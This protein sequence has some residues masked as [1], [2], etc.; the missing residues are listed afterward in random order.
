MGRRRSIRRTR[1]TSTTCLEGLWVKQYHNVVDVAL[2]KR[3][4]A[5]P[6]PRARAQAVRVLC[7]WRDRVPQGAGAAEN[8][9]QRRRSA[10][11]SRSG[12]RG[13]FLRAA[14]EAKE[15]IHIAQR[16]R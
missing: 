1:S 9:G 16:R 8:R 5:S 3:V 10:R 7:Y 6:E 4:L 13:E 15:A 14:S 12:S 2:L 11:A